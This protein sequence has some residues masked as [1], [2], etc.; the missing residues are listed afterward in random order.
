[1]D[2]KHTILIIDDEPALLMGLAATI[3]RHGYNVITATDGNEGLQ[4]AKES[5]PDLILSDV[6]MPP[7]NGFELR[8]LMNLDPDLASTPFIFLTARSSVEDR[9]SGMREGA[10]DYITK[11]FST[12]ELLAR[13][14]AVFRRVETEQ[15]R[16][17]EQ[18]RDI[19]QQDME[20]LRSEILQNFHHELR[21]PLVNILMPLEL[22]ANNRFSDAEEQSKFLQIALSNADRLE[23]LVTDLILLSNIDHGDLNTIRQPIDVNMH[24]LTL[25]RK[26][27]E[28]Y[29]SK[30]LKF[31]ADV[32]SQG[33]ITAPRREF[34]HSVLHLVDNAF[35]FSPEKGLVSLHI[36]PGS[37][38][39]VSILVQ[40]E[41]DGIPP[42]LREKAFERFYQI[43]QGDSREHEGLGVGLTIA[44]AVFQSLKGDVQ[45]L[46]HQKGCH[47]QAFIPD[48]QPDDIVYG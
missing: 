7:P 45:I 17:R 29:K 19:A 21:T 37:N 46:D 10:D 30:Q 39:G 24:I 27:L 22:A 48:R 15:A 5:L 1:M 34:I 43:S 14:E 13:I 12:Q 8:K 25:V 26:R 3:R 23:S 33:L 11:P 9:V 42:E 32:P 28:R 16:G 18:M 40:D 47:V 4:K 38:G 6:M 36:K 31:S 2:R 20:R 35:K 44:R 41:G